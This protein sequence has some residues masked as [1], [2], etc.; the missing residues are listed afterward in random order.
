MSLTDLIYRTLKYG[1][2]KG[3]N[4]KNSEAVPPPSIVDRKSMANFITELRECGY[5]LADCAKRLGVSPSS[6]VNFLKPWKTCL[7]RNG[8]SSISS[9]LR[10]FPRPMPRR[11][12]ESM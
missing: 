2:N 8:G 5:D 6:G 10:V 7:K 12:S 4:F 3:R 1:I 9:S 11:C